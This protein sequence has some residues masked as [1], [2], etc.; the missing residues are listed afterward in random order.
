MKKIAIGLCLFALFF[1]KVQAQSFRDNY[2][3]VEHLKYAA[4]AD[5]A[6]E[7]GDYDA[8]SNYAAQAQEFAKLSD[9]YII[10]M[11]DKKEA[12][13]LIDEAE[14]KYNW[15]LSYRADIRFPEEFENATEY[16]IDASIFFAME[17]YKDAKNAAEAVLEYLA[18]VTEEE[19]LPE[20]F[21]VR[22]L[23]SL[24]DCLWRIAGLPFIYNDPLQWIELY[25]ENR[26][27]MPDPENP[28]LIRP[29]MVLTIPVLSNE[30]RDGTY[31][32]SLKYPVFQK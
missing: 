19:A 6:F 31:D 9:Q 17:E 16:M 20:F 21:I 26:H 23:P 4:M 3:L 8:A 24:P 27:L 13:D 30:L 7:N 18:I 22:N 25:R 10:A 1:I 28:D 32:P 12:S 11:I 14:E 2:Y 29:G 5:E 15:A